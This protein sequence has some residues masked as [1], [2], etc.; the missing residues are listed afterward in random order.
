M[1]LS[2]KF[3]I[4]ATIYAGLNL[5]V[6]ADD[7]NAWR[8]S[9]TSA[10]HDPAAHSYMTQLPH[11]ILRNEAVDNSPLG[12]IVAMAGISTVIAALPGFYTGEAI[13]KTLYKPAP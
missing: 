1:V 7:I 6:C 5:A 2:K 11:M 12:A 10:D 3:K 9:S 13:G 4:Y 8:N